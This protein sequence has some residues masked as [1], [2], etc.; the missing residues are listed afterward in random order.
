MR[1]PYPFKGARHIQIK[2]LH[3]I[4]NFKRFYQTIK[5]NVIAIQLLENNSPGNHTKMHFAIGI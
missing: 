5:Q 2:K 4:I 3:L 1:G